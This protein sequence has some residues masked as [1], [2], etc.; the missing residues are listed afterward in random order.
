VLGLTALGLTAHVTL[1][2]LAEGA[3]VRAPRG[4]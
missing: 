1:R 2:Y 3:D 4:E